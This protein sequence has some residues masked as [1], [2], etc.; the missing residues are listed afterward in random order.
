MDNKND[1]LVQTISDFK[2]SLAGQ[3]IKIH[4]RD[5]ATVAMRLAIARRNLG[6]S[7]DLKSTIIF[8]DDKRVIVQC[9]AYLK[10]EH[11]ATGLAEEYRNASRIN[12]TSALEC[13]ESSAWGRCLA[14]LGLTNDQVASAEELSNALINQDRQLTK[15]LSELDAVSHLGSYQ[16]WITKY[17]DLFK[18][19]KDSNPIAYKSFQEKFSKIKSTLET[20][21]VIKNGRSTTS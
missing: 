8:H 12:Q 2:N 17:S 14:N 20:K 6:S 18:K 21:G 9:D 15:A 13:C 7:L 5:Y 19:V 4:N 11:V 10:N 1:K 16:Q 3:T